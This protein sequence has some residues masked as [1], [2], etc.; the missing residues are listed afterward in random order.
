MGLHDVFN[1]V[2]IYIKAGN[3]NHILLPIDHSEITVF[4]HDTNIAGT[5]PAIA[6]GFSGFIRVVVVAGRNLW[7]AHLNLAFLPGWQWIIMIISNTH[8]RGGHWH[9]NGADLT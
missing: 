9:T 5:Q 6:E 1:F 7:S 4:I 2:W 8:L 3:Q